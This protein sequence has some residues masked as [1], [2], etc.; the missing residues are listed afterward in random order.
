MKNSP[1]NHLENRKRDLLVLFYNK[2]IL[3]DLR[4]ICLDQLHFNLSILGCCVK[5]V[6]KNR[7]SI[8]PSSEDEEANE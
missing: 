6:K 8:N 2:R 3:A 5:K 4:E 7:V 1:G